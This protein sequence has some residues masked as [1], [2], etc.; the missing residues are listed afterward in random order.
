VIRVRGGDLKYSDAER[1]AVMRGGALGTVVA[2]TATAN[3]YV[4]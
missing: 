3:S 1:K 2:E 4:Q